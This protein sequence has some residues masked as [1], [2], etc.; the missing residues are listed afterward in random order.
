MSVAVYQEELRASGHRSRSIKSVIDMTVDALL[1][2][3]VLRELCDI[4]N[5]KKRAQPLTASYIAE[6]AREGVPG[7]RVT[8][9]S[10]LAVLRVLREAQIVVSTEIAAAV[11]WSL[12]HDYL[13]EPISLAT[14]Q[15]NTRSEAARLRLDYFL[16]LAAS[17]KRFLIPLYEL[18]AIDNY[19][20][21]A[22]LQ[23][24]ASKTLI[25]RSRTSGHAKPA[26]MCSGRQ[27]SR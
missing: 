23:R 19:A 5:N 21:P 24:L 25:F 3:F 15:H 7:P 10:V 6:R 8:E 2:R 18:R 16:A 22:E 12:I 26:S 14:E 17:N 11:L 9:D 13:V 1:A 4:P 20:P 27:W